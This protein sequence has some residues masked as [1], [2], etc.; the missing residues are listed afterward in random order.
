MVPF[1]MAIEF[2][3]WG[4][5]GDTGAF[6][7]QNDTILLQRSVPL[8]DGGI[9]PVPLAHTVEYFSHPGGVAESFPAQVRLARIFGRYR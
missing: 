2:N 9:H 1:C 3:Y 8:L 7:H 5:D 6:H 4:V